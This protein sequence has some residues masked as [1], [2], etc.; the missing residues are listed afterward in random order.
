MSITST[1]SIFCHEDDEVT[2][3]ESIKSTSSSF[4]WGCSRLLWPC[5]W[6]GQELPGWWRRSGQRILLNYLLCLL[7][8]ANFILI[9]GGG[10]YEDRRGGGNYG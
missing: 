3:V 4:R 7:N 2:E 6:L 9:G 8:D 1:F 10:G 5:S